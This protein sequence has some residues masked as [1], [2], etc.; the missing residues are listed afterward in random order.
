MAEGE[1]EKV[2]STEKTA[3]AY[4]LLPDWLKPPIKAT[5]PLEFLN[6]LKI[7]Q[8]SRVE[9]QSIR[10]FLHEVQD[11]GTGASRISRIKHWF[12]L[13]SPPE[14]LF[15]YEIRFS[16][17]GSHGRRLVYTYDMGDHERPTFYRSVSRE[18][19][20]EGHDEQLRASIMVTTIVL[21]YL[22]KELPECQTIL[23]G[24]FNPFTTKQLAMVQK[25]RDEFIGS[26][27]PIERMLIIETKKNFWQSPEVKRVENV[28][29]EEQKQRPLTPEQQA[30]DQWSKE[31]PFTDYMKNLFNPSDDKGN[32][33]PSA[34]DVLASLKELKERLIREGK[35]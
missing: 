24:R 23:K 12:D 16:S 22:K 13:T 31:P 35:K 14:S 15:R 3:G 20:P 30:V 34:E 26:L 33:G 29:V 2:R 17:R 19:E 8:A 6:L 32:E 7:E 5:S 11:E 1:A 4:R 25:W 27:H 9:A 18:S 28:A 10:I 21:D